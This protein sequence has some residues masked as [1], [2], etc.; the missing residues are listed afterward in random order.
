M[1]AR[2]TKLKVLATL[3]AAVLLALPVLPAFAADGDVTPTAP[4]IAAAVTVGGV[5]LQDKNAEEASAAIAAIE[6]SSRRSRSRGT[7]TSACS[8]RTRP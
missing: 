7:D 3:L 4:T 2:R 5:L 8:T 1:T 6:T